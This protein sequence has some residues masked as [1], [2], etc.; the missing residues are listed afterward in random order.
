MR[1]LS[2]TEIREVSRE[3]LCFASRRAARLLTRVYDR[4]LAPSG[5]RATQF[6]VL[7][8]LERAISIPL[9]AFAERMALDRTTL[10]RN[11]AALRRDG[12]VRIGNAADGRIRMVSATP[13][14]RRALAVAYPLWKR[15][16]REVR[17]GM[18]RPG[19]LP[20]Q[21]KR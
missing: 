21:I 6:S 17:T 3:C 4:A 14:G 12:L 1:T 16:Q 5:L 20:A 19:S 7:I 2:K 18:C 11:L 10:T 8:G 9:T 13:K 15:T